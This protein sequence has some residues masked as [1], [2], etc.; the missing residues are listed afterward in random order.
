MWASGYY[1]Y[2]GDWLI[3]CGL[4]ASV[5]IHTSFLFKAW[6]SNR[7]PRLRLVAGNLALGLCLL[8]TFALTAEAYL[9]FVSVSTDVMGATL[10]CKRWQA[11]YTSVNSLY[12]RDKEWEQEK[13]PGTYRMAFVGD[14]FVY[15]WG[16]N[17]VENRFSDIIQER[18]HKTQIKR[19]E[20]MNVAWGG[21]DT[22]DQL[23]A[24]RKYLEPYNIDEL[25][26][27]Y[28]PNDIHNLIPV[29][30]DF[31]P[32]TAPKSVY[33]NTESS[34]LLD[35]VYHRVIAPR[36]LETT[37]YG[38]RLAEA[39]SDEEIWTKQKKL[40]GEIIDVCRQRNIKLR[41]AILPFIVISGESYD[42]A[43]VHGQVAN[44]FEENGVPVV[45]L[46]STIGGKPPGSLILSW[47]DPHP[48]EEANRLFADG[49][50]NAFYAQPPKATP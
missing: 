31:H 23:K 48:N 35:W 12:C 30:A 34:F 8:A 24:I 18:F 5:W 11:T 44:F 3:W 29:T 49:I 21:W 36:L 22:Q 17:R 7:K 50:W 19:V 47:Q 45:D 43:K 39:Y 46:R 41:V 16:I 20:A 10:T 26:L 14:S 6:P 42:A 2:L 25:V 28:L 40:L 32:D 4:T 13:P 37:P 1:G 38:D 15:G 9:R 27:C 33:L